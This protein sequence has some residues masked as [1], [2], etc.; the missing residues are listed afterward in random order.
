[1]FSRT[2]GNDVCFTVRQF[3]NAGPEPR[4]PGAELYVLA[5]SGARVFGSKS[6]APDGAWVLW[7]TNSPGNGL[8]WDGFDDC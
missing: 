7:V 1:M 8:T 4:W 5:H 6:K 2:R 3:G